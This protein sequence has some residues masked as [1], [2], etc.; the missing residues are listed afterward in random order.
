MGF[1]AMRSRATRSGFPT[2]NDFQFVTRAVR[3]A[4]HSHPTNRC[5]DG[6]FDEDDVMVALSLLLAVAAARRAPRRKIQ[7]ETSENMASRAG[8]AS[9]S[10]RAWRQKRPDPLFPICNPALSNLNLTWHDRSPDIAMS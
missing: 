5:C 9:A 7:I 10:A 8:Q 4:H 2:C 6:G 3:T 1:L